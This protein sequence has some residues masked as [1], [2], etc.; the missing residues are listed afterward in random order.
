M[1]D[2]VAL[3][4]DGHRKHDVAKLRRAR[5][6]RLGGDDGV[7]FTPLLDD[8]IHVLMARKHRSAR[9]ICDSHM[10]QLDLGAVVVNLLARMLQRL[11]AAR[12]RD[13][14]VF[15]VFPRRRARVFVFLIYA[16]AKSL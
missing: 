4:L 13:G 14:D 11:Y 9:H 1:I 7:K 15:R 5:P 3:D 10:R 16:R 8:I 12:G 6:V 2:V